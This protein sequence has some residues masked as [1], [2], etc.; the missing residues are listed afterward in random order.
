MFPCLGFMLTGDRF[1]CKPAPLWFSKTGKRWKTD[2]VNLYLLAQMGFP[3]LIHTQKTLSV[4]VGGNKCTQS[5]LHLCRIR[6]IMRIWDLCEFWGTDRRAYWTLL[7]SYTYFLPSWRLLLLDPW[8][9]ASA[10]EL[11]CSSLGSGPEKKDCFGAFVCLKHSK[12][13]RITALGRNPVSLWTLCTEIVLFM[14]MIIVIM[15]I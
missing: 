5:T 7:D 1:G 4:G 3:T 8:T 13:L 10:L 15:I 14:M 11:L 6:H 2:A 9:F 12:Y